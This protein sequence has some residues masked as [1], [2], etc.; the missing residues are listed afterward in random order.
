[1]EYPMGTLDATGERTL[2]SLVGTVSVHEV[3][4]FLVPR[5]YWAPTRVFMPGWMKA[6]FTIRLGRGD[7]L[8]P[9]R[10]THSGRQQ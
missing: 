5:W 1:M 10:R 2:T 3:D 7:E 9:C 8:A 6:L 4:A